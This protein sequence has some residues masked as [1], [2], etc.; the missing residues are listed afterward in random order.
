MYDTDNTIQ[1]TGVLECTW[2]NFILQLYAHTAVDVILR[3]NILYSEN[4]RNNVTL[5]CTWYFCIS[6]LFF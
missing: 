5:L 6:Y 3:S 1:V 2:Y 4:V